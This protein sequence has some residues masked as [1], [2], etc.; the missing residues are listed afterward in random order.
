M[1]HTLVSG[2]FRVLLGCFAELDVHMTSLLTHQTRVSK[3]RGKVYL[4]VYLFIY[5]GSFAELWVVLVLVFGSPPPP[6]FFMQLTQTGRFCCFSLQE[7]WGRE[8]GEA[9]V[10]GQLGWEIVKGGAP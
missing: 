6:C 5:L 2:V 4:S 8:A 3:N 10:V 1:V 7:A 9:S